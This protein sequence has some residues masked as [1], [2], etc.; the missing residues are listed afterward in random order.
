DVDYAF[1]YIHTTGTDITIT[2]SGKLIPKENE[3][4]WTVTVNGDGKTPMA[5]QN[6]LRDPIQPGQTYVEGSAELYSGTG[7]LLRPDSKA[8]IDYDSQTNELQITDMEAFSGEKL[9]FRTSLDDPLA[10][11]QSEPI[12]NTAYYTDRLQKEEV[13]ASASLSIGNV[14]ESFLKKSGTNVDGKYVDWQV[15]INEHGYHLSNVTIYDDSWEN[16]RVLR[17]SIAIKDLFGNR[18]LEGIDYDLDHTERYF[19]IKMKNDVTQHLILTYRGEIF[20]PSNSYP[21]DNVPIKNSVRIT[22]DR[23]ITTGKPIEIQV[24]VQVPGSGGEIIGK[25]RD[26][27]IEKVSASNTNTKLRDAEFTLY[28]GDK[29]DINKVVDHGT[30]DGD[31]RARFTKLTSGTYL[32]V[33][34]KAPSGYEISNELKEGKVI[35]VSGDSTNEFVQVIENPEEGSPPVDPE[36]FIDIPVEK[37]WKEVPSSKPTPNVTVRLFA[38]DVEKEAMIL[39]ESNNYKGA[40]KNLPEK[41]GGKEI[42]YEIKE[43]KVDGYTTSTSGNNNGWV[44]TNTYI[45]PDSVSVPVQKI[46]VNAPGATPSVTVVLYANGTREASAEL[47]MSNDYKHTFTN[48]AK[49]DSKGN[50]I[51]YTIE[52]VEIPNYTSGVVETREGWVI[53]N[54]YIEPGI[55]TINIKGKK[56]W[57]D[58]NESKRPAHLIITLQPDGTEIDSTVIAGPYWDYEFKN[59]PKDDGKGHDYVYTIDEVNI[60]AGYEF[61]SGPGEYDITNTYKEVELI[62]KSGKKTWSGDTAT[63]RPGS[64][65]VQLLR[66]GN[67]YKT[68]TVTSANDWSYTFKDLPKDDGAG[69]D[70]TYTVKEANVPSG[71]ESEANGMDLENTY[72]PPKEEVVNHKVVK[73]WVGDKEINRPTEIEVQLYRY[74][75]AEDE[76]AYLDTVKL[77]KENDWSYTYKNLPKNKKGTSDEYRYFANEV[78]V[79]IDYVGKNEESRGTSTITNTY[80]GPELISKSGKKT[81]RGDKESN[82]PS[83]IDIQ[84]LQD[85]KLFK[86]T[87]AKAD[88]WEYRFDNLPKNDGEGHTYEYTVKEKNV[89]EGYTSEVNGMNIINTYSKVTVSGEKRWVGDEDDKEYR[90][91]SITVNLLANGKEIKSTTTNASKNWK[92]EFAD[93]DAKDSDGNDIIYT[94]KEVK[95]LGY[96]TMISG[97]DIVN[98]FDSSDKVTIVV[99]KEWANDEAIKGS[100]R[101]RPSVSVDLNRNERN[102]AVAHLNE[103]NQ[104]Q[105]VFTDL[106]KYDENGEEYEYSVNEFYKPTGYTPSYSIDGKTFIVTNTYKDIP[107]TKI[108]IAGEKHWEDN[109]DSKRPREVTIDLYCNG[110]E[111]DSTKARAPYWEYEFKDLPEYDE[112]GDKNTYSVKEANVP[113]GYEQSG[114]P[115][116]YDITNKLKGPEL[117]SKSGKKTWSG[118]TAANRP[119]SIEVKL[120]Q[121]NTEIKKTTT[122]A[123][124]NWEYTFNDLPKDDGKGHTYN[125]TVKEGSVPP[126]YTSEVNGMDIKNTYDPKINISGEKEWIDNDNSFKKRPSSVKIYLLRDGQ[127][128]NDANNEVIYTVVDESTDWKYSFTDLSKINKET[129]EDY[130]YTV[131]EELPKDLVG[132]DSQPGYV[133]EYSGYDIRNVFQN[134]AKVDVSGTKTWDHGT[135]EASKRPDAVMVQLLQDGSP[136]TGKTQTVTAKENWTYEFKNLPQF[137]DFSH[138]YQYTV[139]EIGITVNGKDVSGDYKTEVTGTDIHN[140][141]NKPVKTAISGE[142]IWDDYDNKFKTRP[143]SIKVELM[144]KDNKTNQIVSTGQTQKVTKDLR[145]HWKYS[146]TNLEKF[147]T[148]GKVIEYFVKE[149][150]STAL[151]Q[152]ETTINGNNIYNTYVNT[153]K[154]KVDVMKKWFD[155]KHN[156]LSEAPVGKIKVTLLQNGKTD[157]EYSGKKVVEL[158]QKNNWKHTFTDL[159]RY[160]NN[161]DKYEYTVI[162]EGI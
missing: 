81:W 154:V 49:E 68:Q 111:I 33:E 50:D 124:K 7:Q 109:D 86:T 66:N 77:N 3:I 25:T 94:V 152:Y 121:D 64:I 125:Y 158:N 54:T 51:T 151:N 161:G 2:K 116:K 71:Y 47:N 5:D 162:E 53:T 27:V 96:E 55:E 126:G 145:G 10:P 69:N 104:W 43:D 114:G 21:L 75:G 99:K 135:N 159:P 16:Q 97:Y 74:I 148:D 106:D 157:F 113:A 105:Q 141:F 23:I 117:I 92:Y 132:S 45:T 134:T 44:V 58:K 24:P 130:V 129:K 83:S 36:I 73:H 41:Q 143:S 6:L 78:K 28:R 80:K 85:G 76:E 153:D 110:Y 128:V 42:K 150:E 61:S 38:N 56:H 9:I 87:T 13:K 120:L 133:P 39:R 90:P 147:D 103:Y 14:N 32:L 1:D 137:D 88:D 140:T 107:K 26:L 40:F 101:Y 100:D 37:Q 57:D 4:E 160:D 46:W 127:R 17:E 70:Y 98:T 30:T 146:F 15:D 155:Y 91:S 112:M 35:N 12:T 122:N 59:L 29:K 82:R 149:V 20:F 63:D 123:N 156:E 72:T 93:L 8:K 102:I 84:L 79:P 65:E 18:L 22:A 136:M 144:K 31:G 139:K 67:N 52:E 11:Y 95:V 60:P 34:T 118:D 131:E 48:L 115:G 138:E 119:G 108:N 19:T 89:P 62:S 142:K